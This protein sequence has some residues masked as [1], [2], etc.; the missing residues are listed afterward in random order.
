MKEFLSL[1]SI[2]IFTVYSVIAQTIVGTDPENK[3]AVLEEF[4]GI[5]CVF[6]PDGH[7]I[8]QSIYDAHPDDVVLI[9]I[10]TGGFAVPS[11][12]EPDFRTPWG[13]AIAGQAD[14]QGYPAGT[15]NRH[16]FPGWSQPGGSGTAMSRNR[17]TS[18]ANLVLAEPSYLNV[19]AEATIVTSTRQLVVYVEVYYTGDSPAESNYLNIALLQNNI[20]GPQTGGGAGNNYNHMHMLRHLITGQWG[21]EITETSQ[22]SLYTGSFAYE[23]PLDYLD[24]DVVLEDLEVAAFVAESHQEVISGNLAEISF[25]ESNELD[26]AIYSVNTPH[27]VCSGEIAPKALIKNYGTNNLT[28]LEFSYSVNGSEPSSYSWTGNLAQFESTYVMLPE[29]LYTATDNNWLSIS[30]DSPNGQTDQLPQ[31]DIFTANMPGSE[32]FPTDVMFGVHVA[33]T[34]QDVSWNIV[35]SEGLVLA[36]GGPYES[37][38]VFWTEITFPDNDCY[39]LTLNDESG[40]G[41]SGG[42]YVIT[43]DNNDV[44]WMGEEFT[45]ESVIEMAHGMIV[46]VEENTISDNIAIYPNPVSQKANIK[47]SLSDDVKMEVLLLD[48]LGKNVKTIHDGFLNSGEH[49]IQIDASELETGMYFVK[50]QT[51]KKVFTKKILISR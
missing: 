8:A 22:G 17:W 7:A 28:S 18:A 14:V 34:P 39:K 30:C 4:T 49:L 9:N 31:N 50:F 19:A 5:H 13:N 51:D 15:V 2:F 29:V 47:F 16:L 6:C 44:L 20:L 46:D 21:V 37:Q 1:L 24:V 26:A 45:Y 25:V 10:H 12:S 36:E 38:G 41:L 33:G 3:N 42:F 23:L 48:I 43:D 11:G 40:E 27:M 35:D 32:T